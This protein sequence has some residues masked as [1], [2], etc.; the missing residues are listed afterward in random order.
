MASVSSLPAK[1][2]GV[3][4]VAD[5]HENA[6]NFDVASFVGIGIAQANALDAGFVRKDFFNHRGSHDFNF[7]VGA[8][9]VNHDF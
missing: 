5:G 7:F 8:H 9:A 1:G 6:V 4:V 2:R 3:G